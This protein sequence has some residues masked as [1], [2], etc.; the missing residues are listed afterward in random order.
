[1]FARL[2][3]R[4]A[5]VLLQQTMSTSLTVRLG[6][7][8]LSGVQAA[9]KSVQAS[10]NSLA[11]G[12]SKLATSATGLLAGAASVAGVAA[13]LKEALDMGG[14]LSD[15]S[16]RTGIATRSLAIL[17]QAFKDAGVSAEGVGKSVA[18]MQDS[19]VSASRGDGAQARA[20]QTLGLDVQRL[21][22]L[23]P[24]RQLAEIGKAIAGLD[25]PARRTAAAMDVFGRSGTELMALFRDATVLD[26]AAQR[27]GGLADVMGRRASEFDAISD[28]L[29]GL[30]TK[31]TGLFAGVADL[32][33][34][35]LT[36]VSE[37][38]NA[39]DL[40]PIGQKI[41]GFSALA[42]QE[43]EAGRF[44]ELIGLTVEAGFEAGGIAAR[45]VLTK[46]GDW[47]G[48][49]DFWKQAIIGVVSF[50]NSTAK[51]L[52]QGV[53]GLLQPVVAWMTYQAD[54]WR[55]AFESVWDLF[56]QLGG[57][58]VNWMAGRIEDM[59]NGAIGFARRLPG[60]SG[61][62]DVKLGRV[63]ASKGNVTPAL[64]L[65][66]AWDLAG[67]T[68][69]DLLKKT[70]AFFD[71]GTAAVRAL[72]GGSTQE[73]A[74][75]LEE[76]NRR[77]NELI[78]SRTKV[79]A[80]GLEVAKARV[81]VEDE[82][83]RKA[84]EALRARA[85]SYVGG[86][87]ERFR[88]FQASREY[89]DKQGIGAG[90]MAG[91]QNTM[92]S[93]GSTAQQVG[94][95]IQTSIGGALTGISESIEGLIRGTMTWADAFRNVG[96]AILDAVVTAFAQM[97]AQMIVSFAL[98]K[99]FGSAAQKQALQV[100]SA[101]HS[102]AI[103]ASIA[104][105]GTAA[106]VGAAAFIAAQSAAIAATTGMASVGYAAGGY[107]G[108]GP[109][110]EVAGLVHR[111]EYVIPAPAVSRIGLDNLEAMRSGAVPAS[112]VSGAGGG[113]QVNNAVQIASF[114]SRLDAKRWANSQE[115]EVWFVDMARRTA[116]KW[117]RA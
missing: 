5:P 61:L 88:Q 10:A 40:T 96:M 92:M 30:R 34:P 50:A 47:L 70:D 63:N 21:L 82:S 65:E 67:E 17:E 99:I 77:I 89:D 22:A 2:K 112:Q 87:E 71:K 56:K 75:A 38:I 3:Y 1:M 95:A 13:G 113:P 39:L 53:S 69:A 105:Y 51:A 16:A 42:V 102:A 36:R 14:R 43:W 116:H 55:F 72:F 73:S 57:Q 6:V 100:G 60:M 4:A 93:L 66:G 62:Q 35:E 28:S 84:E 86:T 80:K 68:R 79:E 58:A 110:M 117:A 103:S 31:A 78:A 18:K 111:G 8:G 83:L 81:E 97:V 27:V 25:D 41:G 109:R 9:F 49:D 98:Q 37:K 114:D 64:S 115:G 12:V 44:G 19:L 76:L 101:W 52:V 26:G 94:Q 85:S 45:A 54:Q 24:D 104:T 32:L 91:I 59:L 29:G 48:S 7:S 11:V 46:V 23:E 20:F 107:T 74:S 90:A 106:G 33:T 15:V 108:D